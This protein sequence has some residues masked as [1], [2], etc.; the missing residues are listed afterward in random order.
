MEVSASKAI[1][2]ASLAL[3]LCGSGTSALA[4][5]I[6]YPTSGTV[7]TASYNF[8]ATATGDIIAFFAGSTAAYDNQL[9]LLVNGV[10]TGV[11]GLDNH[12]SA[13]GQSLNLGHA[14]VGDTLTFVM[15]NLTLGKLAFSNPA[16]NG[17][18]DID[19][20]VG[21]QHVYSTAYTKTSPIID[22]IIP[23][24]TYVSWEDLQFPNSDFNYNDLDFVFTNVGVTSFSVPGPI[25]GAGLPGLI[26][27]SGGLLGW[28]R[29]R[30][31][32]A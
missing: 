23:T 31:K 16:M 10:D 21:H 26:L 13:L 7:N 1:I 2:G 11:V 4:D 15:H 17:A 19:G 29:R 25:A 18:Y 20:S 30:Q 22:P 8:T 3:L 12:S 14:N 5:A 28:W 9:G 27:A 24:G 6:P 32:T